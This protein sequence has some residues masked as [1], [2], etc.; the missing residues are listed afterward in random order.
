M[1]SNGNG[2]WQKTW[3]SLLTGCTKRL[4]LFDLDGTVWDDILVI[5]ND[6]FGPVDE[7]G[8]KRWKSYDR[9]FKIE[10]TMTNGAHLS[11]EYR[12]LLNAKSL[13]ELGVWLR[14]NHKLIAGIKPFLSLLDSF[15][16]TAVAVSNGSHEIA[17]PMLE[18]HGIKMPRVCN[19]LVFDGK[20]FVRMEFFHDEIDG[21]RKGDLVKLAHEDGFEIVGCAGDSK[22]DVSMAQETAR[23]GGLILAVGQGGLDRWCMEN[24]GKLVSPGSW[25]DVSDYS[26]ATAVVQARLAGA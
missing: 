4:F 16:V 21:I 22:G 14:A 15:G 24:E 23:V 7:A 17:D 18:Y 6:E 12:D 8:V 10:N 9:A 3:R 20:N 25:L 1:N 11:A 26:A 13:E 2:A 5:L 19:R